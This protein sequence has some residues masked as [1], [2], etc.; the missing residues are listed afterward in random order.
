[1]RADSAPTHRNAGGLST[2]MNPPGSNAPKKKFFHD[3][4][5]E[6]TAAA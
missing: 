2:V 4:V 3:I 6:R 1:M 5:I